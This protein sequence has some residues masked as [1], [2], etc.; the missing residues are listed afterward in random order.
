MAVALVDGRWFVSRQAL[1]V[2]FVALQVCPYFRDASSPPSAGSARAEEPREAR[3]TILSLRDREK[4]LFEICSV[5]NLLLKISKT[6]LDLGKGR[7]RPLPRASRVAKDVSTAP[8]LACP[9]L[10]DLPL[11]PYDASPARRR[12]RHELLALRRLLPGRV[13]RY[14][15]EPSTMSVLA[16][17]SAQDLDRTSVEQL[18]AS[19]V[20]DVDEALLEM[21]KVMSATLQRLEIHLTTRVQASGM[22]ATATTN[23]AE[24]VAREQEITESQNPIPVVPGGHEDTDDLSMIVNFSV[25]SGGSMRSL[26]PSVITDHSVHSTNSPENDENYPEIDENHPP[27]LPLTVYYNCASLDNLERISKEYG[28]KNGEMILSIICLDPTREVVEGPPQSN[29]C[30][31]WKYYVPL[32]KD[33]FSGERVGRGRGRPDFA[34]K[35]E[36]KNPGVANW[37]QSGCDFVPY[38]HLEPPGETIL[39]LFTEGQH[40]KL[41]NHLG[42]LYTVPPDLRYRL[43]FQ[44]WELQNK[45][46]DFSMK[47]ASEFSGFM[48]TLNEVG[49]SFTIRDYDDVD[50]DTRLNAIRG[51][52]LY[53]CIK[54]RDGGSIL[55]TTAR[56]AEEHFLYIPPIARISMTRPWRRLIGQH[57]KVDHCTDL[58]TESSELLLSLYDPDHPSLDIVTYNHKIQAIPSGLP[59]AV[60]DDLWRP[61]DQG[62]FDRINELDS[63]RWTIVLLTPIGYE[64]QPEID[65]P[66]VNTRGLRIGTLHVTLLSAIQIGL[67]WAVHAWIRIGDHLDAL[68]GGEDIFL[69]PKEHGKFCFYDHND[70]SQ[71]KKCFWIINSVDNFHQSIQDTIYQWEWF[72]NNHIKYV[73]GERLKTDQDG[74]YRILTKLRDDIQDSDRK[75]RAQSKRFLSIQKQARELR[76]GL[77]GA[78]NII[79]AQRSAQLGETVKLLTLVTIFF[80]PLG[81]I[82][83]LWSIITAP[84]LKI[85]AAVSV[86]TAMATYLVVLAVVKWEGIR[87]NWNPLSY[88]WNKLFKGP[89]LEKKEPLTTGE[90]TERPKSR[91]ENLKSKLRYRRGKKHGGVDEAQHDEAR[92]DEHSLP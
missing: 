50:P 21:C 56:E 47:V 71:S 23:I 22:R 91:L 55:K 80:L 54:G 79:E 85:F 83:S 14:P 81:Y 75:L 42:G 6:G 60:G 65:R 37:E 76:D 87:I 67:A 72:Y 88:S 26:H 18:E 19:M 62:A 73:E 9:T 78:S 66:M 53:G 92:V 57:G 49:G 12:A 44:A 31:D 84:D 74:E 48:T 25:N 89:K 13:G 41:S 46:W 45:G 1:R 70:L 24:E 10:G 35:W 27:P 4:T 77:F 69:Q 28:C 63:M 33:D 40:A 58:R 32:Y 59:L 17:S 8:V 34:W 86:G 43:F 82:T 15:R 7:C 38:S 30:L 11:S 64:I 51:R 2:A 52:A 16:G 5:S 61:R 3:D 39:S 90:G 68:L 20:K 29:T 36:N